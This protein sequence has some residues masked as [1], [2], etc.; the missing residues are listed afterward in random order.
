VRKVVISGLA[1]SPREKEAGEPFQKHSAGRE[2]SLARVKRRGIAQEQEINPLAALPRQQVDQ[3]RKM[4]ERLQGK[5]D[6]LAQFV[7]QTG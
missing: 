2:F 1:R 4:S 5:P 6:S 7:R 3:I